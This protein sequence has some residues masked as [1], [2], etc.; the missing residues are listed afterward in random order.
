MI[1]NDP[2]FLSLSSNIN[3]S[4]R[5]SSLSKSNNSLGVQ[6]KQGNTTNWSIVSTDFIPVNENTY[7]NYSMDVSAKDVNQLH[8]KVI[9]FNSNKNETKSDFVF[10]GK[11]GSFEKRYS[12]SLSSPPG[13]KYIKLQMW[14]A[15]NP[16]L[17]SAYLIDN[18]K[19]LSQ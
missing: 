7:Y 10:N 15:P 16:G 12:Q 9:Y 8:S 1:N 2:T 11:D 17:Q 18:V 19:I 5:S 13:T 6:V 3:Q 4:L 14:I